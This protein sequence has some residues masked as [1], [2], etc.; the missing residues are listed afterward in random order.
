MKE[1]GKKKQLEADTAGFDFALL[2]SPCTSDFWKHQPTTVTFGGL[3]C[4][5]I[6]IQWNMEQVGGFTGASEMY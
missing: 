3:V 1:R 5:L 2:L 4:Q 6:P